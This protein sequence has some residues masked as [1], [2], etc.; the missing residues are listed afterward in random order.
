MQKTRSSHSPAGLSDDSYFVQ[1]LIDL[2]FREIIVTE[3]SPT[4]GY[5]A[6]PNVLGIQFLYDGEHDA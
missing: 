3:A 4:N 6:G 2:G 5:H 1:S